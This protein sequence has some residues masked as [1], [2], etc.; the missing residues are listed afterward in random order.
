MTEE[1][2]KRNQV[3]D[4]ICEALRQFTFAFGKDT[5]ESFVTFI[6]GLKD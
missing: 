6:Q 4:E 3:I 2:E 5:V 1:T